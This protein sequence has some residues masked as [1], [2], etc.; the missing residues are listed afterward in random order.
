MNINVVIP[1]AGAGSRF[2]NVGYVKPKPFIDVLGIPMIVRV[3]ENLNFK[4][5]N[6]ILIARKEHLEKEKELVEKIIKDFPVKFITIDELTEGAAITV[7]HT[8]KL[9]NN[10]MPLLIANSDQIVD[11]DMQAY[12]NDMI[13]KE[14]CGS[15]MTFVDDNPKWSYAKI[16][17]NGMVLEV[18]EKQVISD[19]ATVGIYLFAKGKDF[20]NGCI[21]MIINKDKVNGEYYVCPVYNYLIAEKKKIGIYQ[22]DKNKMHGIGTPEDLNKYIEIISK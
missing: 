9:I 20:V 19:Q 14:L 22:I 8:H 7:L 17:N 11:I 21:D 5:A 12:L 6:F 3:L 18:R 1:M 2:A 16:N 10:N 15:I 13:N 4:N